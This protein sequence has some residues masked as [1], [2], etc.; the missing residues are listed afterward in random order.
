VKFLYIDIGS[1]YFKILKNNESI[2]IKRD[3]N[4]D[5]YD[6]LMYHIGDFIAEYMS[7]NIYIS[8]SA[9]RGLNALI[10]GMSNSFSLS[11]SS[12]VAYNSGIN[13]VETILFNEGYL[14]KHTSDLF[15]IV[16]IVGA[17]DGVSN[18][19]GK[20]EVDYIKKLKCS[21]VV[22]AGSEHNTSFVRD[23]LDDVIFVKNILNNKLKLKDK[24]LSDVLIKLYTNDIV[25]KSFIKK[26]KKITSNDIF[27]TPY[28]VNQALEGLHIDNNKVAS[29]FLLIDIGGATTD[30]HYST[31]L[32][33]KNY[34]YSGFDRLVF[35]KLGVHT[36][37]KSLIFSAKQNEYM[38]ELLLHLNITEEIFND[39][40]NVNQLMQLAL[41]LVLYEV[42]FLNDTCQILSLDKLNEIVI[43]GGCVK[44]LNYNE[45]DEIIKFFY[46]TV[47]RLDK[48]P[49]IVIDKQYLT[50][51][52]GINKLIKDGQYE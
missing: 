24:E 8:S 5:I 28:V 52:N 39:N 26:I 9:N 37:K 41:Y 35:K 1:T 42:S 22:Y 48:Y 30:V 31:D 27:P 3:Q 4:A 49:R 6:N 21:H 11:Y 29:P 46:I 17:I 13:V 32:V 15:D 20:K 34:T 44:I 7:E 14:N 18:N 19:I 2:Q 12:A 43:T 38:Y 45:I 36:S 16:L 51:A 23:N 10:F 40:N 50:W 47:L 33:K 25:G